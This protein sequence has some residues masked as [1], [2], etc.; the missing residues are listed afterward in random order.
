MAVLTARMDA[1]ETAVMIIAH[2]ACGEDR[3][4]RDLEENVLTMEQAATQQGASPEVAQFWRTLLGNV[5]SQ[6]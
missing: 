2:A 4:R 3:I 1:I 6:V 5:R